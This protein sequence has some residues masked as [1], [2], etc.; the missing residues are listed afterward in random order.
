MPSICKANSTLMFCRLITD[1]ILK[2]KKINNYVLGDAIIDASTLGHYV[3]RFGAPKSIVW[4]VRQNGT[5]ICL[6]N[7][8]TH[9]LLPI[10]LD[11]IYTPSAIMVYTFVLNENTSE[12]ELSEE[13]TLDQY[14]KG[15]KVNAQSI[16]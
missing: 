12:Y 3:E 14:F 1:I 15:D 6:E 11:P 10:Y 16:G 2:N 8:K 4:A 7:P 9:P 5:T 13:I